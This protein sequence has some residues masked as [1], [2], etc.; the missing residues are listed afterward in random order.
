MAAHAESCHT[1]TTTTAATTAT[2]PDD[3]TINEFGGKIIIFIII[4]FIIIFQRFEDNNRSCTAISLC[5][6]QAD[7]RFS[8][9]HDHCCCY[10]GIF[11]L[12]FAKEI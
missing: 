8:L 6:Y 7:N 5:R 3:F 9:P 12:A 1:N 10:H 2:K 11:V 4:I